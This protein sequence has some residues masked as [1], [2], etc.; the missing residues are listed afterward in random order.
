VRN[1]IL[2]V[3]LIVLCGCT[4]KYDFQFPD[5]ALHLV[6]EA[7]V[8]NGPG[9]H[10]VRLTLSKTTFEE[11]IHDTVPGYYDDGSTPVLDAT[12]LISDNHGVTDTLSPSPGS[13][14]NSTSHV[15]G[16]YRTHSLVGVPGNTYF[17]KVLW[18]GAEYTSSCYMPPVPEIDSV[19]YE[20]M[21]GAL[22]KDNFYIPQISFKD[23][24]E[25][26]DYYMFKTDGMVWGR[27]VIS[28]VNMKSIVTGLNVFQGETHD[29][30]RNGY[31]FPGLPYRI[32]MSSITKEVYNYYQALIMQFRNDGGVHSPSPASPPTN[33]T[34]GALG[35]FRASSVSIVQDTMPQTIYH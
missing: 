27:S 19:T 9:P 34:N 20:F 1:T 10:Y 35:Y 13:D 12:I 16:Y 15:Y 14:L 8:T 33:I 4:E 26:M 29:W 21:Y 23:N 32:E 17:L 18:K 7:V 6:V 2:Y 5:K 22:G 30:W 3:L 11:A 31:P 24:P 28:D 25:T